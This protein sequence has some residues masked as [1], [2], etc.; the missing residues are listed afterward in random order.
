LEEEIPD[1]GKEEWSRE[2]NRK[3]KK[4]DNKRHKGKGDKRRGKP[5]PES[6]DMSKAK[7]EL[8]LLVD[9]KKGTEDFKID[10][11]DPRFGALYKDK[12]YLIDPSSKDF[13]K[14]SKEIRQ[15]QIKKKKIDEE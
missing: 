3:S 14:A 12:R 7:A 4:D 2:K 13:K 10:V 6:E 5:Q 1:T 15:E 11:N 8:E 9:R